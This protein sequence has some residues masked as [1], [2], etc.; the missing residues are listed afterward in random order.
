MF[1]TNFFM[2]IYAHFLDSSTFFMV[3]QKS[4]LHKRVTCK[5]KRMHDEKRIERTR[6]SYHREKKETNSND[7]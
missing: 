3:A 1:S 7:M 2:Y 6:L 5:E 4:V